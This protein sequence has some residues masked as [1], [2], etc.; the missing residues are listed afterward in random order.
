MIMVMT[1]SPWLHHPLYIV[2]WPSCTG[3]LRASSAIHHAQSGPTHA[4]ISGK[5]RGQAGPL[6]ALFVIVFPLSVR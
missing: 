6:Y 3:S 1:V 2:L 5:H 4:R